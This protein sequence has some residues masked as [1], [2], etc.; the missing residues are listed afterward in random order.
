MTTLRQGQERVESPGH[1]GQERVESPD[2]VQDPAEN[3][4]NPKTAMK[5]LGLPGNPG[6]QEAAAA[7]AVTIVGAST[8]A[9]WRQEKCA[10]VTGY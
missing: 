7:A 1:Q 10:Q 3:L 2:Q 4:E 9:T 5:G 8:A 6:S